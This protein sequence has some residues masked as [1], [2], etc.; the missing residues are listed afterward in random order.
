MILYN[1]TVNIEDDVHEK[2]L[3]WMKS[4][5]LPMV[6]GTGKF[7]TYSMYKIVT[8]QE[9]ETGETYSIQ[10]LAESMDD[11]LDYQQNHG[12]ALQ[13]ETQ[14]HFAGKFVAFR[15]LLELEHEH[16]ED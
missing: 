2:W 16:E 14:K 5:H 10:Y 8:K 9:G 12:P 11:L 13:A 15:T 7:K 4:E 1:V 6:M 3:S